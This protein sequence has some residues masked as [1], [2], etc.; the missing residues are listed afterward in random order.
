MPLV[1][2]SGENDPQMAP[3]RWMEPVMAAEGLRFPHI[4]GPAKGHA[5]DSAS[6]AEVLRR[7]DREIAAGKDRFPDTVSVQTKTLRY[8]KIAWVT[9]ERLE[10]HWVKA[11][12][13]ARIINPP[14]SITLSQPPSASTALEISTTNVT[15]LTITPCQLDLLTVPVVID[16]QTLSCPP[17]LPTPVTTASFVK[18]AYGGDV[19]RWAWVPRVGTVYSTT[20]RFGDTG[21]NLLT[22]P[23]NSGA[24]WEKQP[25]LQGPIDDAYLT[26]FLVV[27]PDLMGEKAT[28][29]EPERAAVHAWV[30]NE[31]VHQIERWEGLCRGKPRVKHAQSV[32]EDDKAKYNLVLWG[33]TATN[34]LIADVET[35]SASFPD[36]LALNGAYSA[37]DHVAIGCYPSPFASHDSPK[38]ICLNS[39][40][41][42]REGHDYTNSMQNP[43]LPDWAILKVGPGT[44]PTAEAAGLVEACG[45]FDEQ[46]RL[47]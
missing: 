47:K 2:Y 17:E 16:G 28:A 18:G 14:G 29:A 11:T 23:N 12:V 27:I 24:T 40:F 19:G 30:E 4:V 31:A 13:D 42:F 10:Q 25:G 43:K 32:T 26:P 5:Y 45:F 9:I 38:Y 39:G 8:N 37:S 15:A 41:T 3:A 22:A 46:W 34:S 7:C 20:E 33:T 35:A 44:P 36:L 1:V 6:L 21:R